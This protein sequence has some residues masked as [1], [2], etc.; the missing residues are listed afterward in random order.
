[1]GR[2]E[3]KQ[4]SPILHGHIDRLFTDEGYGFIK[5]DDG[6]EVYFQRDSLTTG[7]WDELVV[8]AKVRF[9]EEIGEKGPYATNVAVQS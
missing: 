5:A 9:R 1:M 3:V 7:V 6:N 2:V 8:D 4:H